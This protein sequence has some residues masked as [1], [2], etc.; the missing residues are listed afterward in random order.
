[1]REGKGVEA[2]LGGQEESRKVINDGTYGK[3]KLLDALTH[4]GHGVLPLASMAP[5]LVLVIAIG[6]TVL[7]LQ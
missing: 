1:M 6:Y 2:S 7:L 4:V 5:H 3:F